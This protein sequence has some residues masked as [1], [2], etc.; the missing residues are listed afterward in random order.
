MTTD[1]LRLLQIRTDRDSDVLDEVRRWF[2]EPDMLRWM[3]GIFG[4][5]YL[6]SGLDAPAE[7]RF[8]GQKVPGEPVTMA[9][10]GFDGEDRPV[11]FAGGEASVERTS[12]PSDCTDHGLSSSVRTL[13]FV[14]IVSPEHRG[15]GYGRAILHSVIEHSSTTEVEVFSCTVDV[16]NKPSLATMRRVRGFVEAD[17]SAGKVP[18]SYS[19]AAAESE[20]RV[21]EKVL[22]QDNAGR[23]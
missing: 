19:R 9:W 4:F 12:D 11:A 1:R 8:T 14:Y 13:G 18:F 22:A 2:E 17:A 5:D 16:D 10:V 23:R 6:V 21:C 15:L 3:G 7:Q 20:A